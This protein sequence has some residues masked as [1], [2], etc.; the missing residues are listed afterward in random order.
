[1]D[2]WLIHHQRKLPQSSAQEQLVIE[3]L[4]GN[5]PLLLHCLFGVPNFDESKL[6]CSHELSKVNTDV[7]KFYRAKQ[8]SLRHDTASENL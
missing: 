3:H 1:M 4:T 7:D 6:L 5:I 8:V 2:Q